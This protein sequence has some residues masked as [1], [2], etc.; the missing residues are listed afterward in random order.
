VNTDKKLTDEWMLSYAAGALTEGHA[1]MVASHL[2]YH[3]DLQQ[4]VA[5]AEAIGGALL[6][7]LEPADVRS[8]L[9]EQVLEGLDR[10]PAREIP[11]VNKSSGIAPQPLVDYLGCE[12]DQL[13]WRIMGPG[14]RN[15]RLWNG[16]A[17]ER[18]WLLRARGGA[19]VPE[20]GHNGDEWTL[21]LQGA[22]T[23]V[24]KKFVV[25]DIETAD[26]EVIHQPLIAD[27][28][29]CICLVLT[30]GP[31]RFKSPVAKMLQPLIGL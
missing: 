1:L 23:A 10:A 20:H 30:H 16:P 18:L 25:G 24:D 31:I 17:D 21:V 22:Y 26:D 27:G 3:E 29:E 5:D 11:V 28:Q 9:L 7:T 12:L 6:D 8:D 15:V 14:M 2:A 19:A 13:K 4:S